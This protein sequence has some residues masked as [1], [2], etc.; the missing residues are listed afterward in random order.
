MDFNITSLAAEKLV[1]ITYSPKNRGSEWKRAKRKATQFKF[2]DSVDKIGAMLE[3]MKDSGGWDA[4]ERRAMSLHDFNA[5]FLQMVA[6]E[7]RD[8]NAETLDSIDWGAYEANDNRGNL[9]KS[10]EEYFIYI[11]N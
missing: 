8:A 2:I 7:L 6:S 3:Y 1:P 10:C 11:G 5:L 4:E 9:F